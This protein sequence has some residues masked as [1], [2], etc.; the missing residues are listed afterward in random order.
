MTDNY[1]KIEGELEKEEEKTCTKCKESLPLSSFNRVSKTNFKLR[2]M[3]RACAL[4]KSTAPPRRVVVDY[5]KELKKCCTCKMMQP[6]SNFHLNKDHVTGM[7]A[8]CKECTRIAG[9]HSIRKVLFVDIENSLKECSMCGAVKDFS[10]FSINSKA[11]LGIASQCKECNRKRKGSKFRKKDCFVD[12]DNNIKECSKCGELLPF[13]CFGKKSKG[14]HGLNPACKECER[15]TQGITKRRPMIDRE[16]KMKECSVCHSVL[17]FDMFYVRSSTKL[18]IGSACKDCESKKNNVDR[19]REQRK[20]YAARPENKAKRKQ[21]LKR[22]R[23]K[24]NKQAVAYRSKRKKYD[25]CYKLATVIRSRN[26]IAL[27]LIKG[28][29][30]KVGSSVENL[31]CSLEFFKSY[32]EDQFYDREDGTKM[33]WL[34][35]GRSGW[36]IDHI[37]PLSSFDL[38]DEDQAIEAAHY[39]NQ[40]PLWAEHNLEKGAR[41]DWSRW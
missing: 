38:T 27:R 37:K 35:H 36:H 18:G 34:S 41:E 6:F 21:Y 40:Q 4:L 8:S 13:T 26:N 16:N 14:K 23:E 15:A 39:T 12:L 22:N 30:L 3:C 25:V 7:A 24:F 11:T 20:V 5:V 29:Y 19:A 28:P 17:P 1:T 10:L 9:G 32:L 33:T 2:S 31:G